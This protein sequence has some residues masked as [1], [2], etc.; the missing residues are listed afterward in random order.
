MEEKKTAKNMFPR[1][2][3]YQL[4]QNVTQKRPA[5]PRPLTHYN[6]HAPK[7][8]I[9][10]EMTQQL[11]ESG[12]IKTGAS[13]MR[14]GVSVASFQTLHCRQIPTSRAEGFR[15]KNKKYSARLH[16]KQ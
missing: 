16:L 7:S 1:S 2:L 12:R 4:P 15:D 6:T 13:T 10:L 3:D 14:G 9:L 8:S 5:H 11:L